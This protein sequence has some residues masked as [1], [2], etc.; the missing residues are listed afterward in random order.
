MP[1]SVPSLPLG[2]TRGVTQTS[3]PSGAN[4]AHGTQGMRRLV[5]SYLS[6]GFPAP[7]LEPGVEGAP[8]GTLPRLGVGKG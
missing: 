4:T 3:E 1:P 8:K 2:L 6:P 5:H 7:S